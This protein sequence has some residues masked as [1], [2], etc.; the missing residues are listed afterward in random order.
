MAWGRMIRR[1]VC[2]QLIPTQYPASSCPTGT[3]SSA[4]RTV[5]A[6]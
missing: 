3:D 5:S 6:Q 4:A 1:M 2:H